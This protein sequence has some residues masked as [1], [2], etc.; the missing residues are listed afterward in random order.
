M[1]ARTGAG[2][3]AVA[4]GLAAALGCGGGSSAGDP[5]QAV[6]AT[7]VDSPQGGT[8]G[9]VRQLG[10]AGTE[11]VLAIA[12][13]PDG[14]QVLL[15]LVGDGGPTGQA[16]MTLGLVRLRP[17]RTVAWTRQY[18][19]GPEQ[20]QGVSIAVTPVFG[21]V[22]LA[23]NIACTV[24]ANCLDFGGGQAAGSLIVKF[25]P[26][27]RFVWQRVIAGASFNTT[28]V[29]VD[30]GGDVA[31]AVTGA[32]GPS[33][34]KYRWDGVSLL[35]IPAVPVHGAAAAPL[36]AALAL[37]QGGN[38]VV[39]DGLAVY[40]VLPNGLLDWT[41]RL[42][43]PIVPGQ[44]TSVG[45]T[46]LNTVVA[47][48]RIDSGT[49]GVAGNAATLTGGVYMAVIERS[50]TP[51]LGRVIAD[52]GR[53]PVGAAVDIAG[54]AAVLTRGAGPCDDRIERWNLAGD[55]LWSRPVAA[56]GAGGTTTSTAVA[57]DATS[58]DVRVGGGFTG[59]MDFGTG[60]VTSRGATDDFVLDLR[61]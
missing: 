15:T 57:V 60:P 4:F 18:T 11:R 47:V 22:F 52:G 13:S 38:L 35:G 56:C 45:V 42:G 7:A 16:P 40:K 51:R 17:D 24:G 9:W 14:G 26:S 10:G 2:R 28:G 31:L 5:G 34:Y 23:L 41:V 27:G 33:I 54:R 53:Y 19:V 39:G 30:P 58:H 55:R 20:A 61:P 21:N 3:W 12:P 36:P 29:A 25:D 6:A 37:D 49:V 8:T 1:C 44:V 59:T 43:S 50:G 48:A 46:A 32:S